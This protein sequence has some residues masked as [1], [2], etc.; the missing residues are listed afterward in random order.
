MFEYAMTILMYSN[1]S[2]TKLVMTKHYIVID[3]VGLEFSSFAFGSYSEYF[4][5]CK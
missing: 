1:S 5:D 4:K 3:I 2:E